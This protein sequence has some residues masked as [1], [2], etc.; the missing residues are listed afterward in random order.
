MKLYDNREEEHEIWKVRESGLGATARVPGQQDTWEGWEDSAV[1][2]EKLGTYLRELRELL[3]KYEYKPVALYGHF[4]QGCVHCRIPFDLKT[5][6]GV[7]RWRKFLD[8]AADLVVRLGGSISGEHGDGQSKANLLPKMFG[9]E[10]IKAFEEFKLIWDPDWKMNPGKVVKPN[11]ISSNLRLGPAYSPWAP[12][13]HFNFVDDDNSL[14]RAAS[15]CVGVGECRRHEGGTMCPS[16]M[17]TKEEMHSTRG[18]AHLLFEMMQGE[19]IQDGWRDETVKEALDLCLA[20][21]GCKSDCPVNVDMATLK[22]EFLSHYYDNRLRPR[23]AYAFGFIH[24]W[25]RLASLFPNIVNLFT[26][27]PGVS[28]LAKF[29]AGAEQKSQ[30]SKICTGDIQTMVC[31]SPAKKPRQ[32]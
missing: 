31:Q 6:E 3:N 11:E 26:Q 15:R 4:G 21:K 2:P 18:R 20:C 28:S 27:T 13:T 16:Y 29:A 25:A 22:S 5:T 7:D 19:I 8:E 24:I 17:V 23:H 30:N 9:D 12:E 32:T 10:M 1:P 14:P